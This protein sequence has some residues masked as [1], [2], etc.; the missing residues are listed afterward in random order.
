MDQ[1]STPF[2]RG[3]S[4]L[5]GTPSRPQ[6]T[7]RRYFGVFGLYNQHAQFSYL[8][9]YK[10]QIFQG[11]N[12]TSQFVSIRGTQFSYH[13]L[14]KSRA[15][16]ESNST[17][18]SLCKV[19]TNFV[20]ASSNN[21]LWPSCL[22]PRT[23]LATITVQQYVRNLVSKYFWYK[24]PSPPLWLHSLLFDPQASNRNT[25]TSTESGINSKDK[26]EPCS[27]PS[28]ETA[29][30][31]NQKPDTGTKFT[32]DSQ[33]HH[34]NEF[35]QVHD[36][37]QS[38]WC[39]DPLGEN[40]TVESESDSYS[41]NQSD[42]ECDNYETDSC[43]SDDF[44]EFSDDSAD[45]QL[46]ECDLQATAIQPTSEYLHSSIDYRTHCSEES[47]YGELQDESDNEFDDGMCSESEMNQELAGE[48]LWRTFEEQALSPHISKP[49]SNHCFEHTSNRKCT[50]KTSDSECQE[51][52]HVGTN[53][54]CVVHKRSVDG[55]SKNFKVKRVRFKSNSELVIV[56]HII[57][58]NFAYRAARRGPWEEYARDRDRFARRIECCA[59][60]L[61]PCLSRKISQYNS[62]SD[63]VHVASDH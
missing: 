27:T 14:S 25:S 42:E 41:L 53:C 32:E 47:G 60:V 4:A 1:V 34:T 57:A 48:I 61:E 28:M 18:Q 46:R 15:F 17:S 22:A 33:K 2:H 52:G 24:I 30:H 13:T 43:V 5:N 51:C 20:K 8:S 35:T 50:T 63:C 40:D 54:I 26:C 9:P 49:T 39:N 21:R 59:S 55:T 12:V 44:V 36:F 45:N 37:Q 29:G 16:Q 7:P 11:T 56:H 31:S 10:P 3:R 23:T 38:C 58:W 62:K 19:T 6:L